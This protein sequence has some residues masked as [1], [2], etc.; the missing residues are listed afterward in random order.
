MWEEGLATTRQGMVALSDSPLD[1]SG[2]DMLAQGLID[3]SVGDAAYRDFRDL[4][5]GTEE[6]AGRDFPDVEFIPLDQQLVFDATDIARRM[7]LSPELGVRENLSV[8]DLK[9]E[10]S[11][12]GEQAGI[13]VVPLSGQVDV[14]ATISNQGTVAARFIVLRLDLVTLEAQQYEDDK[15]IEVLEPGDKASV[16][17][18]NLPVEAGVLYEVT[19]TVVGEDE[20]PSDDVERFTFIMNTDE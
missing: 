3:L 7:F 8:A 19:V 18:E 1:T 17:F 16:T 20:D 12:V 4:A 5:F 10:P 15:G 14:T 9:L 6:E 11:P 13:P 2:L